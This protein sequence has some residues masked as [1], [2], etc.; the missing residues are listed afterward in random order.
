MVCIRNATVTDLLAMQ[1]ANLWCLPENYQMK[2]YYYHIMSWPQLLYVA[3]DHH[4]KI[5]G[6]VLAKMEEDASVPH[7][8]ITSLAVLR[9]HRK[10]GI[11]TKLMKAAQR[12]M[13]ENFKAEYVSL[14][15][16]E[17]NAAAFHLYRKTL[18]YQVYDIEKGYYADGEDAYDMRLPFTEKCNTAMSSNV[19]KWNA[20]LIE[21]GK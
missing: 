12:A 19:A 18:E 9:T 8:H 10:C 14:H 2:Y 21:Q 13:V 20:Y 6:Y 1:N 4:G 16:R 17:T 15:V 3:E 11:A 7:G 5:V